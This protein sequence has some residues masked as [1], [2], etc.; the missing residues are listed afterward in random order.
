[1]I[2]NLANADR[3]ELTG[4]TG[5]TRV[6]NNVAIDDAANGDTAA[7]RSYDVFTDGTVTL[8][9]SATGAAATTGVTMDGGAV[10][11]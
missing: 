10:A 2:I 11:I 6:L 4:M 1:L 7:M 9:I 3:L 8:L 5:M